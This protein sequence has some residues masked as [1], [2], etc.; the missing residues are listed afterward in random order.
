MKKDVFAHSFRYINNLKREI[1]LNQP[2]LFSNPVIMQN[3]F[4]LELCV[5]TIQSEAYKAGLVEDEK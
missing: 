3:I 4:E 2:E 5:R 1:T